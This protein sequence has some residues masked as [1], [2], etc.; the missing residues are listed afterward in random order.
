MAPMMFCFAGVL[1][2][3]EEF[4]SGIVTYYAVTP[5]GKSGY[6]L[7]R[8][9]IPTL[10]AVIYDFILL[11]FFSAVGIDFLVIIVFAISGGLMGIITSLLVISFSRNKMEGMALVKLCG[12]L[13]VGIPIAYFVSGPVQYLFSFF[14]SFW[15]AKFSISENYLFVIPIL[16]S[17]FFLVF[18]LYGRFK[19]R[20]L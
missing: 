3:L 15:L 16:L 12:L 5:L 9:G 4:D 18:C 1:V 20:L 14:P 2:V 13:T 11:F 10:A 19:K 7:S 17:S 6:L 8:I